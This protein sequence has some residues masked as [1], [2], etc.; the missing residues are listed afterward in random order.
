MLGGMTPSVATGLVVRWASVDGVAYSL[1]RGTNLFSG[2]ENVASNLPAT[3]PFNTYIDS[4]ATGFG[5]FYYRAK[6]R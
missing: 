2:L 1:S 3:P 5:P 4:N 6:V